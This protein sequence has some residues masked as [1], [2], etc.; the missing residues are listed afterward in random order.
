M[1]IFFVIIVRIDVTFNIRLFLNHS[2]RI[3]DNIFTVYLNQLNLKVFNQIL[4]IW[5]RNQSLRRFSNKK[6]KDCAKSPFA[7]AEMS[8]DIDDD[9]VLPETLQKLEIVPIHPQSQTACKTN[10]E[11]NQNPFFSVSSTANGLNDRVSKCI[12]FMLNK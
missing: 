3:H 7:S 4:F 2:N 5:N 12:Q 6:K 11:R 9:Q 8:S 1:K 10:N